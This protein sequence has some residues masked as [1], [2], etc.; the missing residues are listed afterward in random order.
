M[1]DFENK[2]TKFLIKKDRFGYQGMKIEC[3]FNKGK[4]VEITAEHLEKIQQEKLNSLMV[5]VG[6]DEDE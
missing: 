3:A 1:P 2:T 6:M 4:Y 5:Q